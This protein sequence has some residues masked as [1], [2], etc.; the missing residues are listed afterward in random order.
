MKFLKNVIEIVLSDT[1]HQKKHKIQ[2]LKSA[3]IHHV[4]I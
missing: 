1:E 4:L 3:Y 2:F